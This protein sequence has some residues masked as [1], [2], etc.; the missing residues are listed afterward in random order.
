MN[1]ADLLPWQRAPA[2]LRHPYPALTCLTV[3]T[4]FAQLYAEPTMLQYLR[5]TMGKEVQNSVIVSPDA[6][7]AK[8][9]VSF[10]RVTSRAK[11]CSCKLDELF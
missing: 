5:D 10:H 2:F 7:G 4:L 1:D 9:S 11:T 6:G 8:R 3:P